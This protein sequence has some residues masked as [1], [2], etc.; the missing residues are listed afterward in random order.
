MGWPWSRTTLDD[1]ARALPFEH[2]LR[3]R[4]PDEALARWRT[5]AA[6]WAG[7]ES[8][9]V[10]L[11]LDC[12]G[13]MEAARDTATC[14]RLQAW[15]HCVLVATGG[16]AESV[17]EWA[18]A[19]GMDVACMPGL[20]SGLPG[21][22]DW[23]L[24]A[25]AGDLLHPSLAGVVALAARRGADAVAW[26]WL[27]GQRRGRRLSLSFRHRAPWR[28]D[29]AE[30]DHDQRGR[31]FAVPASAWTGAG[32]EEAWQVRM[33]HPAT[34]PHVHPEPLQVLP[35]GGCGQEFSPHRAEALFKVAFEDGP[36][37]PRPAQAAT[38]VSVVVLYR[39]RA[40]LTLRALRSVVAQRF[41]GRLQLVL[42]DNQS[43]ADTRDVIRRYLGTLPQSVE[44]VL[45]EYDAPFNHSRQCN[46]GIEAATQQVVLMLNNDVELLDADAVDTMA[47]W[48]MVPGIATAGA[49]IVDAEGQPRGGGFRCR[50]T[51]GAESNS[52]V[53]EASGAAAARSRMTVGNTFACVA[54]RRQ[55]YRELGGLD[56]LAFPVGYNDVD[57]C[58]RATAAGWRHVN[59][60]GCR[61]THAVG[62]SRSKTDEVAQ[63]L[64][65]RVAHPWVPVVA[66][67]ERDVEPVNLPEAKLPDPP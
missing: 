41:S 65:L 54:M 47:R 9:R 5:E 49:C 11:L 35:P 3:K 61:A 24:P 25:R 4:S 26:D 6:A 62:A 37:G 7:C 33:G 42:V 23:V 34:S 64:A 52:P 58:L 66:L 63:K 56:E 20:S 15:P 12:A 1:F 60:A 28:D 51:P 29:L 45:V 53:E 30:L 46:L 10:A 67:R 44:S 18:R 21:I 16:G 57:F 32:V 13:D 14:W 39:D 40:E 43:S 27:E 55:A 59:L 22:A 38:G 48:A 36:N 31:A 2:L 50:R 19:R 17:A 8:P